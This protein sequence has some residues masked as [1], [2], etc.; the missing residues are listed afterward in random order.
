MA[1]LLDAD[2]FIQAQNMHYSFAVC[3]GFWGW[4]DDAH[5]KGKLL[6]IKDVRDE[7]MR[8]EDDLS[9][10][11]K[12]RSKMFLDR[13]DEGTYE[14]LKILSGWV[15]ANYLSPAQSEFFGAADFFLVGYAH[16]HSHTV[17]THETFAKGL[18]VKIPVACQAMGVSYMTPFQM[19]NA[20]GAK[21]TFTA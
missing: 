5:S 13:N 21:F 7:L 10:W 9:K 14:S 3:P 6:S 16:A 20:E 4:L 15:E 11:A 12:P 17:V 1:Y 18:K 2:V 19:L 8:L